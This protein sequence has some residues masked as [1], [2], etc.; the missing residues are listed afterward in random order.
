SEPVFG[1]VVLDAVNNCSDS[2]FFAV[3][4][5]TELYNSYVDSLKNIFDSSY[6]AKCMQAYKYERFTVTHTVSEYHQTLYYY[7]QAGNLL[8][9]VSPAGVRANYD[10]LWL[11]SVA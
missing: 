5:S 2:S 3:S 4:K 7:D 11:D 1:P 6:R 10:S 9:T 8:K